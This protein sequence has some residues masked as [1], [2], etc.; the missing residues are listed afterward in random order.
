MRSISAREIEDKISGL[1]KETCIVANPQLV[2]AFEESRE[3]EESPLAAQT[4]D[5]LVENTRIAAEE[6]LPIC[7][8]TG[9]AVFF[10]ELGED[11]KIEGGTLQEAINRGMVRGYEEGH[12]RKSTCHCFSRKNRGDNS[13]AFVHLELV[14]GDGLKISFM[15]KGGGSENMGA[16]RLLKPGQGWQGVA[17]F[18]VETVEKAGP[19][20]CPPVIV[21]VGIGGPM[22]VAALNSKRALLGETEGK[23]PDP[24]LAEKEDILL[25]RINNLGIGPEG[26]GGRTT[27]LA[28]HIVD[29]PCHIASLP[30]AVSLAC[31][32]ARSK[33]LVF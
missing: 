27:A 11:A 33:T 14:A 9:L 6:G 7:Q 22:E 20:P 21:G 19:N 29:A 15:A 31:Q 28:V 23:N 32:A 3:K 2:K 16:V 13:P 4:L 10:V 12:L 25:E 1:C 18:V 26:F 17:D 8:D 24:D 5:R 30:V